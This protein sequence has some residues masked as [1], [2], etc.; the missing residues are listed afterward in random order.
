VRGFEECA[1]RLRLPVSGGGFRSALA[2]CVCVCVKYPVLILCTLWRITSLIGGGFSPAFVEAYEAEG[3]FALCAVLVKV[4]PSEWLVEHW[5]VY[6]STVR[7]RPPCQAFLSLFPIVT[8]FCMVGLYGR[9]GRLTAQ[10]GG[11]RPG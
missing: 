11:F 7:A 1:R 2:P 3:L 5:N 8:R 9:A 4:L 6:A 10:N